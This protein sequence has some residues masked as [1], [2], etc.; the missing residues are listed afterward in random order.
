M[1]TN[2]ETRRSKIKDRRSQRPMTSDPRFSILDSRSSILSFFRV[3][4]VFHGLSS[5]DFSSLAGR[6]E[7]LPPSYNAPL[8]P[9][10]PA[11]KQPGFSGAHEQGSRGAA[12]RRNRGIG[13]PIHLRPAAP[14]PLLAGHNQSAAA[15][16]QRHRGGEQKQQELGFPKCSVPLCLC[17]P[18]KSMQ[19]KPPRSPRPPRGPCFLCTLRV[20]CGSFQGNR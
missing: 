14:P 18:P 7:Y 17:G 4:G 10:R 8:L 1:P 11:E 20:L 16:T 5:S 9:G 13:A 15:E 19:M 2:H 6:R 3:I 12:A